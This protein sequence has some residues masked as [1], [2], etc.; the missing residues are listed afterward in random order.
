M[1]K[2]LP[3]QATPASLG[4]PQSGNPDSWCARSVIGHVPDNEGCWPR[5]VQCPKC[6]ILCYQLSPATAQLLTNHLGIIQSPTVV[7]HC[8]PLAVAEDLHAASA[9]T[10]RGLP[11]S[12]GDGRVSAQSPK[13]TKR[14]HVPKHSPAI[15]IRKPAV[16]CM[17]AVESALME[18][19]INMVH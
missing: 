19:G 11:F 2:H 5:L 3:S 7:T 4:C 9:A 8:P 15:C 6:D 17:I 12:D 13:D 14:Q 16:Y 18:I 1:H 10:V